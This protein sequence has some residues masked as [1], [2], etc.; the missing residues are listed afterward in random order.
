MTSAPSWPTRAYCLV[1]HVAELERRLVE[2]AAELTSTIDKLKK[3]EAEATARA[4]ELSSILDAIPGIVI[5]SRDPTCDHVTGNRA[6]YDLLRLPYDSNLSKS[7][8]ENNNRCS[9]FQIMNAGRELATSELPVR[10]AVASGREIQAAE[11]TWVSND[12]TSLDTLGNAVPLRDREGKIRGAVGVFVD[13]T[14]RNQAMAALRESEDRY[15]DLVEHSQDLLCTH[16]LNG[17][18]LSCNPAAARSLG[19]EVNQLLD[20]PLRAVIAPEFRVQFDAYLCRIKTVGVDKGAMA[21]ITRTGERRIWEYH[22]TL[23][24]EA[25]PAPIVRGIAH[26]VTERKR[27]ERSLRLFRMLID[28]SN[29]SVEVVDPGTLRILDV[30]QKA[31]SSLGYSREELLCLRIPDIESEASGSTTA[32]L[33]QELKK[34]RSLVME[35]MRR[36]KDGSTFP[37]EVSLKWVQL[38][39]DYYVTIAR[40]ITDR[41]QV[42]EKLQ[43]YERVIE[44]YEDPVIV[45]DRQYRYVI[46]NRAFLNYRDMQKEQVIGRSVGEVLDRQVFETTIKQKMDECFQGK[47]IEYEMQHE[48]PKLGKR[49][50]RVSYFP[51]EGPG[52]FDRIVCIV[53]DVTHQKQAERALQQ[54]QAEVARVTRFAAMGELT[55]SIAHEI[56]QPLA[57][58]AADASA[59]LRWLAPQPPNLDEAREALGRAIQEVN[60]AG[61]VIQRIRALLQREPDAVQT[62]DG[63]ELICETLLLAENEL[64][65][66]GVTVKTAL[67]DDA[68]APRGDRTQVQQ[69]ILN[70]ILNAIDAMSS[71]NDRPRELVIASFN[72]PEGLL[73]QV[74]DS[75]TGL[76]SALIEGIFEPFFT[77]KPNGIGLG[78]SI[79]RSIVEAHGGHLWATPNFP[80][81]AL[82]QFT[83]ARTDVAA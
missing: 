44:G 4:E 18:V 2:Q 56:N 16:D 48:Y 37:V 22:N 62:L 14:A 81:G 27:A 45:V 6:T 24:A 72:S 9:Q 35:R 31:C 26:D 25:I 11:L 40:D 38:E 54:A 33:T 77:T 5:I 82:F 68:P 79:S 58:V 8:R 66:S 49:D 51:I 63:N 42:V 3:S 80:R 53:R 13:I 21:V 1:D 41:K 52:G 20:R 60:R 29:E 65:R 50:L 17:K 75:G 15:R 32:G 7:A 28:E 74:Q 76:D 71:V 23:R 61:R 10:R 70:L 67:A 39:R 19:Y 34:S 12:G 83:L 73:I 64:R 36:R 59:A 30:N 43:E 69:V 78:L 55:A 47:V 46:A 57:A